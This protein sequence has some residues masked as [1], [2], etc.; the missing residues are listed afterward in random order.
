MDDFFT[1][2]VEGG[3]KLGNVQV[4][5]ADEPW[6]AV[7]NPDGSLPPSV[8]VLSIFRRHTY[9]NKGPDR[10]EL[11]R[12]EARRGLTPP[13]TEPPYRHERR[14]LAA[15]A[16][17]PRSGAWEVF[18]ELKR[19]SQLHKMYDGHK[20]PVLANAAKRDRRAGR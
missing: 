9:A 17:E 4:V 8:R 14:R 20:D 2:E 11:A 18:A 1:I 16:R 3:P 10:R 13:P 19:L 7:T 5:P 15:L 12:Y 6:V